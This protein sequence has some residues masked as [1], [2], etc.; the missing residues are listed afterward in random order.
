MVPVVT[1]SIVVLISGIVGRLCCFAVVNEQYHFVNV[2]R[3][4]QNELVAAT[5]ATCRRRRND[6]YL[7]RWRRPEPPIRHLAQVAWLNLHN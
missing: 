3:R 1:T 4:Q 6:F 2:Y 5:D 7:D